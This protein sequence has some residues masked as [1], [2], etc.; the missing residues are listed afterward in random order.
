VDLQRE[1]IVELR[2]HRQARVRDDLAHGLAVQALQVADLRRVRA[3][4]TA[5]SVI[6]TPDS[7]PPKPRRCSSHNSAPS[8]Q[9]TSSVLAGATPARAH[10]AITWSALPTAPSARQRAYTAASAGSRV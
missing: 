4:A 7:F 10:S 2:H 3:I 8:P 6:S 5:A 1:R 9:P